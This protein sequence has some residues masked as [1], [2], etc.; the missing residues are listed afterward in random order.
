MI[1]SIQDG[2]CY[3][4]WQDGVTQT[5]DDVASLIINAWYTKPFQYVSIFNVIS[6]VGNE[7]SLDEFIT[8][9]TE[10]WSKP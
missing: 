4:T 7:A 10:E 9:L 3:A 1:V 8:V 5:W 2:T 6:F